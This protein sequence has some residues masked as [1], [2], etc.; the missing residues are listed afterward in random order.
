M[1]TPSC[2]HHVGRDGQALSTSGRVP[3]ELV[4]RLLEAVEAC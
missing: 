2:S 3:E 4:E 1:E